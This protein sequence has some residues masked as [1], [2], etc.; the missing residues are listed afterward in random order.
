[1]Q[2]NEKQFEVIGYQHIS[3]FPATRKTQT[4][5]TI[6]KKHFFADHEKLDMASELSEL[7]LEA[8]KLEAEKKR[9]TDEFK[10]KINSLECKKSQIAKAY[11]TGF[12]VND[13]LCDLYLDIDAQERVWVEHETLEVIRKEPMEVR[14]RQLKLEIVNK[15]ERR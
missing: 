2:Q 6:G 13:V 14:D 8:D 3:E 10:E 5:Q 7:F 9:I 11:R 15:N 4:Q 12:E 1:M